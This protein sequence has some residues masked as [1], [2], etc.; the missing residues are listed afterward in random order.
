[1]IVQKGANYGYPLREGTQSDVA[2]EGMGPVPADDTIPVQ[3]S[4]TVDARHGQADV[5]GD[6]IPAQPRYGGDAI[7]GGFVYRGTRSRR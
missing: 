5:S 4:D 6:R 2:D 7:A 3:I 1:M